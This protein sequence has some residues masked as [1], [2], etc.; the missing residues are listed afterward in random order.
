MNESPEQDERRQ[1]VPDENEYLCQRCLRL[2]VRGLHSKKDC[3]KEVALV[4]AL[5]GGRYKDPY[6]D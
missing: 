5:M 6:E 1:V 4:E 3:M 2:A